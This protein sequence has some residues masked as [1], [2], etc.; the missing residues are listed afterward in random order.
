MMAF[1]S[2]LQHRRQEHLIVEPQLLSF[3]RHFI[4]SITSFAV[5]V[6]LISEEIFEIHATVSTGK[7]EREF[8][9]F[10]QFDKKGPGDAEQVGRSLR[11]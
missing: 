10:R 9:R 8:A 4:E 6:L 1:A 2:G 11:G 3:S 5:A 7:V